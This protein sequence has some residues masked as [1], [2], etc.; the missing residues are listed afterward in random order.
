M[1]NASIPVGILYGYNVG[2]YSIF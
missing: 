1:L 2:V